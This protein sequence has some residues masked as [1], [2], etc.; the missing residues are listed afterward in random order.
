VPG[1]ARAVIPRALPL[2]A[3]AAA[4]A[5]AGCGG[6]G[7][8]AVAHVAGRAIPKSA[9]EDTV[10][11]FR[12]EARRE[13]HDFP[14]DGTARFEVVRA[15][16]LKLLVARAELEAAAAAQ[17]IHVTDAEAEQRLAS[18]SAEPGE[19]TDAFAV[20]TARGQIVEERLFAEATRGVAVPAAAA[21]AYYRA[22]RSTYGDASFGSVAA[23]I[24]S[25][26]LATRK[27]EAMRRWLAAMHRRLDPT[28]SY[29][30]GYAP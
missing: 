21:R 10:T 5:A 20:S 23:S 9:L 3:C 27:N 18:S 30:K 13:G 12:A 22:H 15:Q 24:R 29:A 17:G 8:P 14:A 16:L 25:Q 1:Y 6:S 4:A 2:V 26:L 28:I 7:D 19:G 11:H